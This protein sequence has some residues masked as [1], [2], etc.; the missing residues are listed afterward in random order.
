M[1]TKII[2]DDEPASLGFLPV[3]P[4]FPLEGTIVNRTLET[5]TESGVVITKPELPVSVNQFRLTWNGVNLADADTLELFFDDH[6]GPYQ[7]FLWQSKRYYYVDDSLTRT[8]LG[9]GIYALTASIEEIPVL[10]PAAH[11]GAP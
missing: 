3:E 2:I 7:S 9:P 6:L 5:R 8:K 10:C 1:V 11:P 4:D